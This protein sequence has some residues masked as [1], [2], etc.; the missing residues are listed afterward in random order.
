M[1]ACPSCGREIAG[2]F[3]FCPHCGARLPSVVVTERRKTVTAVF[4]D[5]TGSTSLGESTDPEALREL[6]TRYFDRMKAIVERHGGTVE[7]FIGDAVMAVFGMPVAH[8]DDALRA[9]RAA[10]EMRDAL[11]GIGV[12]ARIGVNT[13]EVVTGSEDR[14]MTGD[15]INVAARLEQ[16]AAPGEVLIGRSTLQLVDAAVEAEPLEPLVVKGKAEPVPAFRLV[17]VREAPERRHDLPFVGRERELGELRMASERASRDRRCELVTVMGEAGV[18]KSRLVRELFLHEEARVVRGRCLPYGEGIT[19]WPVVDVLKQMEVMPSDEAAVTAIRSL[20]GM[21]DETV[22]ADDIAWAVRKTFEEAAAADRLFVVVFDDIQWAEATFLDLID[23]VALL[24]SNAPILLLCMA[25]PELLDRR[26]TWPV[27]LRLEPLADALVERLVGERTSPVARE[28]IVRAAG[29]N[30]LFVDE[31][32]ALASEADGEIVV[33][34]TLHAL[35]TSRLDQLEHADRLILEVAAVEGEIVHRG[36]V[37]NLMTDGAEVMPRLASLV[38]A[39]LLAP[40]E[41]RI[42]GEDAFRFR[43]LL[44]RD[45]AYGALSKAARGDLHRRFASW[46][47]QRAPALTELDELVGYHLEQSYRY[48]EELGLSEDDLGAAA[49]HRLTSAGLKAA[50]RQDYAGAVRLLE[51]AAGIASEELDLS[52]ETELA[53]ALFWS[54]R[55]QDAFRRAD[56]FAKR[57]AAAGDLVGELCGRMIAERMRLGLDPGSGTERLAA[58]VEQALPVFHRAGDHLALYIAYSALTELEGQRAKVD[59]S[60]EAA[61][62]ASVHARQGGH[63]A[64][65]SFGTLA[66]GRFFGTTPVQELMAWLDE[67]EHDHARDYFFRAY[68]AWSL[69]KLGRFDE[70]R[71]ILAVARRELEDR[72]STVLL[73]NITAFESVGVELLAGDPAA[74]VEFGAD[75]FRQHEELGDQTFL[76]AAAA[77][78][79]DALYTL[80][81]LDEADAWARR[82][83]ELGAGDDAWNQMLWRQ[84]RAKVQ[85]RRGEHAEAERLAREAVAIADETEMLDA[86]GDSYAD[87]GEVLALGG[88]PQDAAEALQQALVRY[89]RKGNIVMAGRTRH[90]LSALRNAAAT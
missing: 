36:A 57:A 87:L 52:L 72:G 63:A 62:R 45:A 7:K 76:P 13:G 58:L 17:R 3:A 69:A 90:R 50:G 31:M 46:L 18:G 11:P 14:P 48:R 34:P 67:H 59:A 12:K 40:H 42:S 60:L 19:Y 53:E 6:L 75:G 78:L 44:I 77:G 64:P 51:R 54:G 38:R 4:C 81:R 65:G 73:A 10:E 28:Q 82:S 61:E 24:S 32:L 16:T 83:Q 26:P 2:E 80:D 22:S 5:L 29:G 21:S 30:P 55:G 85:A 89:E 27:T 86:Q 79:A 20:L 71:A 49:R 15:A 70:A 33:P 88:R 9:V 84:V 23:H 39:G 41:P 56:A 35:L 37:Q 74:A 68:R 25:R 43:H 1:R 47:E 8:E 66:A